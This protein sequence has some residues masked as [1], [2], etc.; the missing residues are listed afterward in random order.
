MDDLLKILNEQQQRAVATPNGPTMVLAGPGSGKTRVLT[1]RIAYLIG[2]MN[3]P[4]WHILAVTFTNK[5]AREMG[6]RVNKIL[7]SNAEGIWLGTFHSVCG[8]ILRREADLLPVTRDFVIFDQDDQTTLLK[9]II[10]EN[11]LDEK[12]YRPASYLNE[13]SRAKN[14]LITPE[15][16]P[17]KDFRDEQ[18]QRLY[19]IYQE[20]L[21]KNNAMDFDDMLVYTTQLLDE[22]PIVRETYS[23][24]FEHI[25]VDEFQD[26]N[27][28][29]YMIIK[30]LASLHQNLYLVGDEDQSIYRWR[31]ADY[32]NIE[33][34]KRDFKN[35]KVYLL[36]QNYRSTQTILDSAMAVIEPNKNRTHKQLET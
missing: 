25:L 6:D 32:R 10:K 34:F 3:V 14:D 24:K 17:I 22:Y 19:R 21:I 11:N 12:M 28:A 15:N 29:Q 26:T 23:H 7:G 31:G 4:A 2:A 30:N 27:M 35:A 16:Y 1:Y 20:R 33:R 9:E 8:K 18:T 13:I 36:E 5:A